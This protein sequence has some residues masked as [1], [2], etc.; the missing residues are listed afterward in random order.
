MVQRATYLDK[1]VALIRILHLRA[2]GGQQDGSPQS[3]GG[4]I[5]D[6][7]LGAI[8]PLPPPPP[9]V[10]LM[11]GPRSAQLRPPPPPAAPKLPGDGNQFIGSRHAETPHA[12]D[13]IQGT[14]MHAAYDPWAIPSE[15]ALATRSPTRSG[16]Q[17]PATSFDPW[18]VPR[19]GG[20]YAVMPPSCAVIR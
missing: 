7:D 11:D 6:S 2:G 12:G 15:H 13:P 9:P 4:R 10:A 1:W 17:I 5:E 8:T 18:V 20:S 14:Q 3:A 19:S 16:N